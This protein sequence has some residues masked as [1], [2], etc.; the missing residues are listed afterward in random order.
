MLSEAQAH[1]EAEI[2]HVAFVADAILASFA[3]P[4]LAYQRRELGYSVE[5]VSA[6]VT[7]LFITGLKRGVPGSS[8][9]PGAPELEPPLASV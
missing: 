3:T 9:E 2:R 1:G 4:L 6:G 7:D 5:R 8:V